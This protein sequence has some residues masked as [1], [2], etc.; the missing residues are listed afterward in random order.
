[1]IKRISHATAPHGVSDCMWDLEVVYWDA[2]SMMQLLNED[3]VEHA[4]PISYSRLYDITPVYP[5]AWTYIYRKV[6]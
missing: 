5:P 6:R 4:R 3:V 1:M 2:S